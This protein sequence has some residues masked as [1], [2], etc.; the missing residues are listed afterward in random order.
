MPTS[1]GNRSYF[2]TPAIY[3]ISIRGKIQPN[4]CDR[5]E[6]MAVHVTEADDGPTVTVL[7]GELT[8][9]ASLTGL[10]NTLFDLQL[11]VLSVQRIADATLP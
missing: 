3:Q 7:I 1:T 6:G 8:D 2:D 4:W 10:L 5:L 9:Q 11:P